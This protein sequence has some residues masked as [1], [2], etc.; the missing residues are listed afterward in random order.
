MRVKGCEMCK[1]VVIRQVTRNFA[2][3]NNAGNMRL[4]RI[5]PH[6]GPAPREAN[7]AEKGMIVRMPAL[8]VT[9]ILGGLGLQA[10]PTARSR[11]GRLIRPMS[12]GKTDS[13]SRRRRSVSEIIFGAKARHSTPVAV[14]RAPMIRFCLLPPIASRLA[15]VVTPMI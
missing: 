14:V 15:M 11:T 1:T 12:V 13:V 7:A 5:S 9:M 8:M 4:K 10:A 3:S 6:T 2:D